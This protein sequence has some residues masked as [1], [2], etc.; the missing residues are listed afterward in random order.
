M[1]FSTDMLES[2]C[3]LIFAVSKVFA[4]VSISKFI[5]KRIK[6]YNFIEFVKKYE[7]PPF[8]RKEQFENS[9]A[10]STILRK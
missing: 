4:I 8:S 6:S 2:C 1:K 3:W 10:V 5:Q 7:D 9:S